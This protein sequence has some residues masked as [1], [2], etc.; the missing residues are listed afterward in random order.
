MSQSAAQHL[1][2]LFAGCVLSDVTEAVGL[3]A[4][5]Q[6]LAAGCLAQLLAVQACFCAGCSCLSIC[7]SCNPFLLRW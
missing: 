1:L 2:M 6:T 3:D 5:A 4:D 7:I